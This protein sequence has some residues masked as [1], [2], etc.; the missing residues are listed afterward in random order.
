MREVLRAS[1]LKSVRWDGHHIQHILLLIRIHHGS[2]GRFETTVLKIMRNVRPALDFEHC[3]SNKP[4]K[5]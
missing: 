2:A 5:L 3:D 4:D 1:A